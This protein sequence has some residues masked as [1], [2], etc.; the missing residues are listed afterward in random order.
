MSECVANCG[1]SV[2][3]YYLCKQCT[4]AFAADLRDVEWLA[5]ELE[6]TLA[7]Q[8]AFGAPIGRVVASAERPL[9]YHPKAS[10]VASRLHSE[11]ATWT[12]EIAGMRGDEFDEVGT[13]GLA[14]WL[15]R[16]VNAVR[17]HPQAGSIVRT[18]GDAVRAARSVVDRPPDK[19]F[20]GPCDECSADMYAQIRYG[21]VQCPSCGCEYDVEERRESLLSVIEDQWATAEELSS[22]LGTLGKSVTS[23]RI[24]KWSS[25]GKLVKLPPHPGDSNKRPRYRVAD[26]LALLVDAVAK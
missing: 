25:R 15:V 23:E 11:L 8:T 22:A 17:L 5:V 13:Q 26:V 19:W 10:S 9:P 16:N 6:V 18:I 14:A 4:D 7:R 21:S 3:S 1:T 24:R 12:W 20:A 2:D